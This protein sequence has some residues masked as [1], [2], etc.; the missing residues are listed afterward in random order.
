MVTSDYLGIIIHEVV[1]EDGNL[2]VTLSNPVNTGNAMQIIVTESGEQDGYDTPLTALHVV[3]VHSAS[4]GTATADELHGIMPV[5]FQV[6]LENPNSRIAVY[7]W[8]STES[9]TA[10]WTQTEPETGF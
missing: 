4:G 6:P 10:L 3:D 2:K 1:S 9:M 7:L 5:T 8:D